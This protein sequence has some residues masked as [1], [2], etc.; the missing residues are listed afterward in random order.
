[1]Q[2]PSDNGC[3][4][5]GGGQA[6]DERET[7]QGATRPIADRRSQIPLSHSTCRGRTNVALLSVATDNRYIPDLAGK[8][9]LILMSSAREPSPNRV[10]RRMVLGTVS[11]LS[12]VFKRLKFKQCLI[13]T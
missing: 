3:G 13:Y 12:V 9:I 5:G 4:S 8:S 2:L 1:M 11:K 6:E 10:L 7:E